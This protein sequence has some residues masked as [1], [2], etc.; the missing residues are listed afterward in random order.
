MLDVESE[1]DS[2]RAKVENVSG[3]KETL[4]RKLSTIRT[5]EEDYK[6][7]RDEVSCS[8]LKLPVFDSVALYNTRYDDFTFKYSTLLLLVLS[9]AEEKIAFEKYLLVL[10]TCFRMM[11]YD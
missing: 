8:P 4:E 11:C 7:L 6:N 9:V 3:E 1:R 2:L 5:F 10:I